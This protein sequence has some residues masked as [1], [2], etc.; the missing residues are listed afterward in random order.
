MPTDPSMIVYRGQAGAI[1]GLWRQWSPGRWAFAVPVLGFTWRETEPP[2]PS[3][4]TSPGNLI[5]LVDMIEPSQTSVFVERMLVEA[6]VQ[7]TREIVEL[8]T[9]ELH[10]STLGVNGTAIIIDQEMAKR[11]PEEIAWAADHPQEKPVVDYDPET[12]II[13]INRAG[14]GSF[15]TQSGE[16]VE[17]TVT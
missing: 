12:R 5:R 4:P 9:N 17:V 13:T 10:G 1:F 11:H 14:T 16:T 2:V 3:D 8:L 15:T 6:R 7:R